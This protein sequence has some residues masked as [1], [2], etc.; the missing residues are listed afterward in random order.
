LFTEWAEDNGIERMQDLAAWDLESYETERRA[1]DPTALTLNKEFGTLRQ[2]LEYCADVGIV[3]ECLPDAVHIPDV[4]A[5]ERSS[6]VKLGQDS[7]HALL[8]HYRSHSD[9]YG[10]RSHILLEIA[11]HTG[12]RAGAIRA[13]DIRDYRSA[14]DG[15][16]YLAFVNRPDTGTRLKKGPNG[17]R[18]VTLSQTVADAL[19]HFIEHERND[20]EDEHGRRPLLASRLGRPTTGTIRDWMY[21]AT[22]PCIH[23]DCPHGRERE[24]CDWTT[25]VSASKCPS[26]R[27]PHQ[28]RTGAITWMRNEGIPAE[29]VASRVNS[30]V[31]TIEEHYDKEDP[32]EEMLNRRSSIT[33][34]LDIADSNPDH[35]D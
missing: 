27:S 5:D 33:E 21:V 14:D 17:E 19:D 20:S 26:S 23:S 15:T 7:A 9:S 8:Q 28:V 25:Q 6:D 30:G 24:S 29:V 2:W 13:L 31:D 35:D 18:P 11:W 32:V 34:Q 1:Q 10:S 22:V 3:D 4:P 12:A 16:R